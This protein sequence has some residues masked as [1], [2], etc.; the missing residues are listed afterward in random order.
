MTP[1]QGWLSII[2]RWL[3]ALAWMALVFVLSSISGLRVSDDAGIEEPLRVAAHFITYAVMGG[4]VLFGV[5]AWPPTGPA[6][7]TLAFMVT[8]FY[9]VSDEIHQAFVPGRA[10]Q[11]EDVIVDALGATLGIVVAWWI[12]QGRAH[13]EVK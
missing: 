8:L 4:V 6:K 7:A 10:A 1:A 2:V 9:A 12:L 3:P 11:V 13:R 5:S